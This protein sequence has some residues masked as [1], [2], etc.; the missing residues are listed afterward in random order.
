MR[1][2]SL[3]TPR[4]TMGVFS[5]TSLISLRHARFVSG[6]ISSLHSG[7]YP[8]FY[9]HPP[10]CAKSEPSP[11]EVHPRLFRRREIFP[12]WEH[13]AAQ[14]LFAAAMANLLGPVHPAV[15]AQTEKVPRI[16][17]RRESQ[18]V[19]AEQHHARGPVRPIERRLPRQRKIRHPLVEPWAKIRPPQELS[20][21]FPV[22]RRNAALRLQH[23]SRAAIDFPADVKRQLRIDAHRSSAAPKARFSKPPVAT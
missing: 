22:Q 2:P 8:P 10:H 13:A 7:L 12:W 20:R 19:E 9:L 15:L 23:L 21:V 6:S 1:F 17:V 16:F 3:A 11:W 14:R 5:L 18:V 4:T